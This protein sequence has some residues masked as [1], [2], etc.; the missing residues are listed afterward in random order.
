MCALFLPDIGN[1]TYTNGCSLYHENSIRGS[2]IPLI[3]LL[4]VSISMLLTIPCLTFLYLSDTTKSCVTYVPASTSHS[5]S[6][7]IIKSSFFCN[8]TC[9][10]KACYP[11]AKNRLL[12]FPSSSTYVYPISD[13]FFFLESRLLL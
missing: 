8:I 10:I 9:I 3:L 1:L 11:M 2:Q 12:L 4:L 6:P 5:S 13:L 7:A